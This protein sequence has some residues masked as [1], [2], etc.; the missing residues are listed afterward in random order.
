MRLFRQFHGEVLRI[1]LLGT[2]VNK[3]YDRSNRHLN[4]APNTKKP[5]ANRFCSGS[6]VH[7]RVLVWPGIVYKDSGQARE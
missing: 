7:S 2:R 6:V 3:T 1:P 5:T 4:K